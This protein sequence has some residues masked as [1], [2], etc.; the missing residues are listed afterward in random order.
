MATRQEALAGAVDLAPALSELRRAADKAL[1]VGPFS[2]VNKTG[3]PPDGDRHQYMSLGSYWWPNPDTLGGLPY[4]RRDGQRNPEGNSTYYDDLTLSRMVNAVDT[5]ALAYYLTGTQTY[6]DH[7][8]RLVQAWFLDESTRMNP[9]MRYAQ[10]IPGRPQERGGGIIDS[11]GFMRV[12]DAVGLLAGS[13]SWTVGDQE[14]LQAWFGQLL[15]WLRESPQGQMESRA[16][17]NHGS[18]YDAQVVCYA[19]FTG[20]GDVAAQVVAKSTK[21]RIASQVAPDGRQPGELTRTRS[22]DYSNFNLEALSQLATLGNHV[23]VDL[24]S[25]QT[26]DGRS[27]RRALDFLVPY[28]GGATPWLYPQTASIN[29]FAETAPLLARA[30]KAYPDGSYGQVLAQ[31]AKGQKEL[32]LLKLRLGAWKLE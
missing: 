20:Q 24:W 23:G 26:A 19:L 16:A 27:I 14:A 30:A 29:F 4:V 15:S 6:A 31:L 10:I 17:N 7:A 9:N 2:V 18:W 8:T 25:Y 28:I 22:F 32:P 13:P 11:R 12:V 1:Q 21:A 5:L 3:T